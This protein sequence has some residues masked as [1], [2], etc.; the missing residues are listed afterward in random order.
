M[1]G[2]ELPINVMIIIVLAIIVLLAVMALFFG[3]WNPGKSSLSLETAKS[4]ACN[5]LISTGCKDTSIK[6]NNF[7]VDGDGITNDGTNVDNGDT[8]QKLCELYYNTG[9]DVVK[10][11]AICHC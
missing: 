10:C 1:K 2:V 4:S 5:I 9:S 8:L 7:D 6:V 11:K 3:V